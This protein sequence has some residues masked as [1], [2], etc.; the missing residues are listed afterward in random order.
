M[1]KIDPDTPAADGADAASAAA[2]ARGRR[3]AL[4][5]AE[6]PAFAASLAMLRQFGEASPDLLCIGEAGTARLEYLSPAFTA[7]H[8]VEREH[9]LSGN[10][11]RRWVGLVHPEDRR[12][13]LDTLR[14]APAS[15]SAGNSAS[16]DRWTGRCAGS[17]PPL[18]RY[19]TRPAACGVS[20]ASPRT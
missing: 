8:G 19:G 5:R 2:P 13:A 12:E 4:A 15:G 18:F 7:I 1:S 20:P 11:L 14:R 17:T 10:T 6:D 3:T 9:M 16:C